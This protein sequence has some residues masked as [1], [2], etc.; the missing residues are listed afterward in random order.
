MGEHNEAKVIADKILGA[1]HPDEWKL[2][3]KLVADAY[4]SLLEER[5][6]LRE[7]LKWYADDF[8][9]TH[10]EGDTKESPTIGLDGKEYLSP[11]LG[12]SI[13]SYD[14]GKRAR[15]ALTEVSE[16]DDG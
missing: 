8:N 4:L 16:G 12:C 5:D 13:V 2:D 3:V 9:W 7:A 15:K 11:D 10:M 6:K 1:N 14:C